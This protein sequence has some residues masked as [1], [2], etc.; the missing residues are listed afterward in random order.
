MSESGQKECGQE[1]DRTIRMQQTLDMED[2]KLAR[3]YAADSI[4][5]VEIPDA[6]GGWF[7]TAVVWDQTPDTV[8]LASSAHLLTHA[9]ENGSIYV[10][11]GGEENAPDGGNGQEAVTR[12]EGVPAFFTG[13]SQ[14]YDIGFLELD[15]SALTCQQ[16]KSLRYVRLHQR[17]FDTLSAGDPCFAAGC[18]QDGAADLTVWC[19][20]I[21]TAFSDASLESEM[22]LFSGE[23]VPGMS[24][25]GVFDG[26]GNFIGLLTAGRKGETAAL[27]MP[28]VNTAY[29]EVCKKSRN[30]EDYR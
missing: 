10:Y 11:P 6:E 20:L 2:P 25:S 27:P 15:K 28:L 1:I 9:T 3:E 18:G 4:V 16:L 13:I 26:Y 5:R 7:G 8:V 23:S 21:E 30:T 19:E 24:G 14:Q 22:L 29:R 17:I 12:K